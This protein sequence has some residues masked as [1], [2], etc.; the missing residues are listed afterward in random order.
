MITPLRH[1][2]RHAPALAVA[3]LVLASGQTQASPDAI[4]EIRAFNTAYDT[5]IKSQNNDRVLALWASDGVS[6]LPGQAAIRGRQA[7]DQFLKGV[8]AQ[9]VGWK[10]VSQK[11]TCHDIAVHGSW[12]TEWCDTHQV[13]SRPDGKPNWEGWGKM[14]LV[15]HRVNGHWL[16]RQEMWNQSPASASESSR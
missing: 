14:A 3:I 15:L 8:Q 10:V 16:I 9:A 2:L 7:I 13:A 1:L 11:S 4:A 5:A 12:G 6:L